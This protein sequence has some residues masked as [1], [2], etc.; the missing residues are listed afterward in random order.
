MAEFTKAGFLILSTRYGRFLNRTLGTEWDPHPGRKVQSFPGRGDRR[1]GKPGEYPADIDVRKDGA[2]LR[3]GAVA[4][5]ISPR[6]ELSFWN[7]DSGMELLREKPI[8][9]L[10]IPARHF[11]DLPG[12][13][14]RIEACFQSY[15]DERL[16]GLGQH[17]HGR[18]DQKGCVIDL[19][20]RNTEVSIPFLLSSRGYGFLW[21][22]PAVGRVELGANATRWV[23]EAAPEMDYWITAGGDPDRSFPIMRTSP[24]MRRCFPGGRPVSGRANCGTQARRS[25]RRWQKNIP[26]ES[27]AFGDRHRF[28]PLDPP[29]RLAI[30]PEMLAGPRPH[31]PE[32]GKNGRESDGIGLADRQPP[33]PQFS[34]DVAERVY[35]SAIKIGNPGSF[36]FCGCRRDEDGTY[37]H[38]YDATN[39]GAGKYIWEKVKQG[40]YRHGIKVYWLDACEPEMIPMN[41]ET[42]IFSAGKAMPSPIS[43]LATM[44][45]L[46]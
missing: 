1:P 3:N 17:Q 14:H 32:P 5:K 45:G 35:R 37:I 16:Y 36:L 10:S 38:Y 27:A 34:G 44:F 29:G 28:L 42:C 12:G 24:G 18:L 41:P 40:Y 9:D 7:A 11:R 31:G 2:E 22:N 46:F 39:P 4:V 15:E 26:G 13:L 6:G 19:V 43:T 21:N 25:W 30:R 20:Q 23:A 8:H 33:Q